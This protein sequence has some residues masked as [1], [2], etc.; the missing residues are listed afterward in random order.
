MYVVKVV[1]SDDERRDHARVRHEVYV[2]EKGWIAA[3]D[4]P[5]GVER[6]PLDDASTMIVAYDM[7]GAPVGAIRL[8][9]RDEHAGVHLPVE[10]APFHCGLQ[11]GRS[12]VEG[13]RL[14]VVR[15]HRRDGLVMLGLCRAA[16]Q[17]MVD[18]GVDDCYAIVERPLLIRLRSIGWPFK[19]LTE[20]IEHF[21]GLVSP[22]VAAVP[23]IVAGVANGPFRAFFGKPFDG[24]V[25]A[26]HLQA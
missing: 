25:A 15:E 24:V 10:A 3:A 16:V 20:P 12:A 1:E 9:R 8:I 7:C 6:D 21:G 11:E 19:A 5:D 23:D 18:A 13:S 14:A 26:E 17:V 22:T 2:R 4:A